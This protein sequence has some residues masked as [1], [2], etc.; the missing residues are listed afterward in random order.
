MAE[1]SSKVI[2]RFDFSEALRMSPIERI[3]RSIARAARLAK[4]YQSFSDY[5]CV[6]ETGA[7]ESELSKIEAELGQ[8]LP[9]EYR[10]FLSRC[11]Y[12]KIDDGLEVGGLDHD[13]VYVTERPWISDEHR[14]GVQ[15]LVFSN[16]W[17]YADGDQLM[18][19]MGD[20]K[21]AVVA[22]LHEHGPLYESFAPS[23]SLALW[24]MVHEVEERD[25]ED[26]DDDDV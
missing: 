7:T 24:R 18:F 2:P 3:E 21:Y 5:P 23:F 26:D 14:A 8:S 22:Y 1:H 19:D 11:R 16:Y 4:S 20:P 25:T 6:P 15:Y 9:P 12:L 17:T 10:G 13:G